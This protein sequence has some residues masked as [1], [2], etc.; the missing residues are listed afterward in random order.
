MVIVVDHAD[1]QPNLRSAHGVGAALARFVIVRQHT[2]HLG[3]APDFDQWKTKPFLEQNMQARLDSGAEANPH[4]VRAFQIVWRLIQ[5]HG[6]HDPQIMHQRC[7][8][9]ANLP[10]P[11]PGV[12][13][14]GLD[15]A[16]ARQQH[17]EK[18]NDAGIHMIK[19]QGVVDPFGPWLQ[20][21]QAAEICV[22]GAG[23]QLVLM[24]QDAALGPA[25]GAGGVEQAGLRLRG[26]R[27]G[28]R[29]WALCRRRAGREFGG[30]NH[31]NVPANLRHSR[32]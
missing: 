2:N 17:A 21:H 10:P 27:P 6:R 7:F 15:L 29:S 22:P 11:G 8:G 14:V 18:G 28:Y 32:T 25:G 3:H 16:T 13:A 19:R 23:H 26:D 24:R 4:A 20:R 31:R 1:F 9:F 12:K 5:Q 30:F